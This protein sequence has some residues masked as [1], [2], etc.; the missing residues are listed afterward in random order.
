[1]EPRSR[2]PKVAA[3]AM[4]VAERLLVVVR[5]VAS[6]ERDVE[7]ADHGQQ[8]VLALLEEG[9]EGVRVARMSCRMCVCELR[10]FICPKKKGGRNASDWGRHSENT[11]TTACSR[12]L[13][14]SDSR[15]P[16]IKLGQN[17]K[18]KTF[19]DKKVSGQKHFRLK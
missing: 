1:M 5:A 6:L 4:R 19:L 18:N 17:M 12:T 14:L 15:I 7:V 2:R 10:I 3:G 13:F 9:P 16:T 8:L 11:K